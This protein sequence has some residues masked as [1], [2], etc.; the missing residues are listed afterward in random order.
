M[1]YALLAVLIWGS[2]FTAGKIA[3]T[4]ADPVLV[5]QF[6]F[7]LAGL[8]VAPVFFKSYRQIPPHL[9]QKVWWLALLNFPISFLL[10][11]IG[12]QYTSASVAAT[13]V[14]A[15]PLIT[16]LIGFLFFQ[17][18]G[19]LLDW[20]MSIVVFIGILLIVI[21]THRQAGNTALFGVLLIIAAAV[22]FVFCLYLGKTLLQEIEPKVYSSVL[23]GLAPL[24][25]LPFTLTLTQNWQITP[26]SEGILAIL[27]LAWACGW[28]AIHCWNKSIQKISANHAG[29]I[30]ALEP[31]FGVFIAMIW[32]GES[33]SWLT[34]LGVILVIGATLIAVGL[35]AWRQYRKKTSSF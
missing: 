17:Q 15:E 14:G 31:V 16:V 7:L 23:L 19:K 1:F 10:Q 28:L 22:A 29:I 33:L 21:S 11:F 3:Y 4:M 6:R 18:R 25:C 2:S 30:I 27:Y 24:L 8:L 34:S 12:L 20:L 13:I 35:P 26:N 9:R 32:L 5:T